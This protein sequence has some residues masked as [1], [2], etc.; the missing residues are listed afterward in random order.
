MSFR[1]AAQDGGTQ[2]VLEHVR[3]PADAVQYGAGWHVH[4][5]CLAAHLSGAGQRVDGCGDADFL[6]AYQALEPRYAAAATG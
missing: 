1:L 3:I 5:D 6:A 2:L 4:L